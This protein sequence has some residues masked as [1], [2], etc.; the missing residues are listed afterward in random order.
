[1]PSGTATTP[2]A[3]QRPAMVPAGPGAGID[4]ESQKSKDSLREALMRDASNQAK[5]DAQFDAAQRQ[6][7]QE[8]NRVQMSKKSGHAG[9]T[10]RGMDEHDDAESRASPSLLSSLR[11]Y[12]FL[13]LGAA[14]L[15]ALAAWMVS[16]RIGGFG[17]RAGGG[18][19]SSASK[20]R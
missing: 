8:S 12:R 15:V 7:L 16:A 13:I 17:R 18:H 20:H 3:V 11:E 6:L 1:M 10:V 5:A 19:G 4:F 14:V 9:N 2:I